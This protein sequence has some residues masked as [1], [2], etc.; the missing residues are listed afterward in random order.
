V[1]TLRG[2]LPDYLYGDKLISMNTGG[3]AYYFHHDALNTTSA[4]T[5]STAAIEWQLTPFDGHGVFGVQ[6][7]ISISLCSYSAGVRWASRAWWRS[8]L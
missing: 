8:R 4:V 2:Q 5:K 1:S 7:L 6:T 3:A